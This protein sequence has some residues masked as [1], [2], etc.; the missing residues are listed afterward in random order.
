MSDNGSPLKHLTTCKLCRQRF[1]NTAL[2][3]LGETPDKKTKRFVEALANHLKAAHAEQMFQ[4]EVEC[5]RTYVL[6]TGWA[7]LQQFD[8]TDPALL[9]GTQ[10][11]RRW[12]HN[13]TRKAELSDA[14]IVDKIVSQE[15]L[16][17]AKAI[18]VCK[19]IRDLLTE[20]GRYALTT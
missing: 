9:A 20:Q 17:A 6:F 8:T 5:Q 2:P 3:I 10:S 16:D 12:L 19:E 13:R 4:I 11:F 18:E 7:I 15:P 14:E 1:A